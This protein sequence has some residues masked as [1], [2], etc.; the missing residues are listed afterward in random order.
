MLVSL[1][2]TN[3]RGLQPEKV[4]MNSVA[5]KELD[6]RK[7]T[8]YTNTNLWIQTQK[9][10]NKDFSATPLLLSSN[11]KNRFWI[12]WGNLH[13]KQSQYVEYFNYL[14]SIISNDI[15]CTRK[16]RSRIVIVK[17]AINKKK[18]LFTRKLHWILRK[19]LVK[20]YTWSV[21]FC[22]A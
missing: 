6:Y 18:N 12:L 14:D 22:D 8:N 3:W 9:S 16:I 1:R 4:L 15:R 19:K 2:S 21:A 10:Q 11:L 13:Q 17:A 7:A 5:V 20:C